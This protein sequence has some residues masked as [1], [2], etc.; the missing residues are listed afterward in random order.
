MP[1]TLDELREFNL[2]G[3]LMGIPVA[4]VATALSFPFFNPK[5]KPGTTRRQYLVAKSFALF[6]CGALLWLLVTVSFIWIRIRFK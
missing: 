5:P 3:M 4:V 1:P 6:Y 2:T